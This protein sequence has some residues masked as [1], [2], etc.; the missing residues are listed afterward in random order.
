[1]AAPDQLLHQEGLGQDPFLILA[2]LVVSNL[3]CNAVVFSETCPS[4]TAYDRSH[5]YSEVSNW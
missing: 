3:R 2:D 4:E 1:L 5:F